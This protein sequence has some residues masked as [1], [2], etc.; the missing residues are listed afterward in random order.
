VKCSDAALRSM[1]NHGESIGVTLRS[2]AGAGVA[3][4][5]RVGAAVHTDR[6]RANRCV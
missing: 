1:P 4:A 2:I 5:L 3:I 6:R